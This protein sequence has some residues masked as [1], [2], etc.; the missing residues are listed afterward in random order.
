MT[1]GVSESDN[2]MEFETVLNNELGQFGMYQLINI[3]LL[4]VPAAASG[5][6]AGDYV[7]TATMPCGKRPLIK[8]WDRPKDLRVIKPSRYEQNEASVK[9]HWKNVLRE[10]EL[11]YKDE[12]F[13]N[14]HGD[15]VRELVGPKIFSRIV[16]IFK[17]SLRDKPYEPRSE[18]S[19]EPSD[20]YYQTTNVVSEGPIRPS[21]SM[22]DFDPSMYV[23]TDEEDN[24][25]MEGEESEAWTISSSSSDLRKSSRSKSILRTK[26]LST[27]KSVSK[28][29]SKF[30]SKK[31][32]TRH[33]KLLKST[34]SS[35]GELASTLDDLEVQ[36]SEKPK[37]RMSTHSHKSKK[38]PHF[39]ML[40]CNK[41][42]TD[43]IKWKSHYKQKSF[44]V[45]ASDEFSKK[46][47]ILTKKIAQEF[48]DWWVGLGN[49][50]FKSEIRRPEDIEDLFQVWF[51]EHASRG[52]VLD[53]K[54][55]PC[56]LKTIAEFVGV[57]KASCP[58]VL[59]RQIKDDVHAETSP[60][61]TMAFGTCLPQDMKHIPPKNNTK[62]MWHGVKIP[63]DLRSMACVWDDIQHLTSTKAFHK[64]LQKRP[65]LAM[66]PFLKSLEAPGEKK[67]P[68][69]VPSDYIIKFKAGTST[70]DLA[71]PVSEFSLEL[72]EVLSKL[73]ND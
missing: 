31:S 11:S 13:W 23:D 49:V 73:L 57:R 68:F 55:L 47:E 43:M 4:A 19:L 62:E 12:T 54:I 34:P 17:L 6:M 33:S 2:K 35:V 1:Q 32:L 45:S 3:L 27:A 20:I 14:S 72:K 16:K 7:F 5:F 39:E 22:S 52:L 44:E 48:Y 71:L 8:L 26:S 60:A 38:N 61:H 53:H 58:K 10:L 69:V 63:E 66:P 50:E 28:S 46:A 51:D 29:F 30:L 25:E 59:K 21:F 37:K 18:T 64:W 41:S 36:M 56:V 9:V 70:Q 15:M 24:Q 40:Y 42:E 65:H 67:Q